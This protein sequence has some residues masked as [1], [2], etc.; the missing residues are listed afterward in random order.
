M[1]KTIDVEKKDA[2]YILTL[3]EPQKRNALSYQ[4]ADEFEQAIREIEQDPQARFLILTGSGKAFCAGAD[5]DSVIKDMA[6]PSVGS[7]PLTY[8]FYLKFLR[9]RDMHLPT[10]AA[11]NGHAIGGGFCLALACDMRIASNRAQFAM[12]FVQ[13]G[14]H[15]GMG[16]TH[17]L[18]RAA[19]TARAFEIFLTGDRFSAQEAF[20]MGLLNRVVEQDELMPT[21]MAM[22][23]KIASYPQLTVQH[24]KRSI[25]L[26]IKA[27]LG[28]MM[29]YEVFAQALTIGTGDFRKAVEAFLE[30]GPPNT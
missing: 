26:G 14:V 4:M 11:V 30:K 19:G 13:L 20:S 28:E 10:L 25:Y 18:P 5:F 29:H 8:Q 2:I 22:A 9:M 16:S 23:Q 7:K 17:L 6:G 15:P 12:N 3:N 24:L 27:D 21:A 1:Y